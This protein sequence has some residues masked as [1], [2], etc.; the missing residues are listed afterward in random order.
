MRPGD[1][2]FL[3]PARGL[4]NDMWRGYRDV[5]DDLAFSRPLWSASSWLVLIREEMN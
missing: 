1:V 2:L 4:N 5:L 3:M